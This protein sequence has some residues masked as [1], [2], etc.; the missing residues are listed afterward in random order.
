MWKQSQEA[1]TQAERTGEGLLVSR[2]LHYLLGDEDQIFRLVARI[3]AR[4]GRV[5]A[6]REAARAQSGDSGRSGRGASE[7]GLGSMGS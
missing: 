7:P 2:W 4:E 6:A 3:R 1:T 5:L